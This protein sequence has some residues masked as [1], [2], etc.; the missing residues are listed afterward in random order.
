M[1]KLCWQATKMP[2]HSFSLLKVKHSLLREEWQKQIDLILKKIEEGAVEK[3]V[4][5]R[6]TQLSFSKPPC[7][8]DMI[9]R[10]KTHTLKATL[11]AFQLTHHTAFLGASPERLFFRK[12]NRIWV[13][14]LAATRPRGKS[15]AED[16]LLEKQLLTGIKER[17]EF[18]IVEEYIRAHIKALSQHCTCHPPMHVLKTA[19]VQ[20][21]YS[22]LE[23]LLTPGISD[24]M[25]IDRLHP[26]PAIGGSPR[27][28]AVEL[29]L[30]L[31]SFQRGWY[32]SPVGWISPEET[33]LV[34]AIRSCL[35]HDTQLH[36]FAAAGIVAQ[37]I[38]EQE[39]EELDQKMRLM[40]YGCGLAQ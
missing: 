36:L 37:S 40:L 14:I 23:A 32:S 28:E 19:H 29:L 22:Q 35:L 10:L 33:D 39:W 31:E 21:L 16:D 7:I 6:K 26:T 13:D 17:K 9:Q 20:H 12:A 27:K 34:V 25:L 4:L 11:F 18:L 24:A 30:D 2:A 3:I 8:W 1:Q 38:A 5:G 15:A